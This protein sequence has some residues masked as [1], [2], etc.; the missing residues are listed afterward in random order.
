MLH[1]SLPRTFSISLALG[2]LA[3][4]HGRARLGQPNLARPEPSPAATTS[5]LPPATD[6]DVGATPDFARGQA[7][8]A[9]LAL[10]ALA[11]ARP[12]CPADASAA[13]VA[14]CRAAT[15]ATR[16]T[17]EEDRDDGAQLLA[18]LNQ[19]EVRPDLARL[20][21]PWTSALHA[22][23]ARAV[24]LEELSGPLR[25]LRRALANAYLEPRTGLYRGVRLKDCQEVFRTLAGRTELWPDLVVTVE[26]LGTW[27]LS[28]LRRFC[29]FDRT[30]P[31]P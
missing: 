16:A 25:Q 1:P 6:R 10:G 23:H 27:P 5:L 26:P 20:A 2:A 8:V 12:T 30:L 31:A 17:F 14:F 7:V 29:L 24:L 21:G 28:T 3:C 18:L 15:R 13:E 4:S 19:L 11:N 22:A 9:P